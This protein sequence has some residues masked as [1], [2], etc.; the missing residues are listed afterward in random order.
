MAPAAL[1]KEITGGQ[2]DTERFRSAADKGIDQTHSAATNA[3]QL[4]H[5]L[6]PDLQTTQVDDVLTHEVVIG[7]ALLFK[8]AMFSR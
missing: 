7:E 6:T 1:R 4:A 2:A 8:P 3:S 5:M